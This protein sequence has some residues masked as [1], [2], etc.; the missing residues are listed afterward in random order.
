MSGP[1]RQTQETV[2]KPWGPQEEAY[3][4]L[5]A[6]AESAFGMTPKTPFAGDYFAPPTAAQ[7]SGAESVKAAAPGMSVGFPEIRNLGVAQARG[8][9]L[10]PESN[11]FLAATIEAAINPVLKKYTQ[12]IFP[13]IDD[14]SISGGAYGGARQSIEQE[15]AAED[16]GAE[17]SRVA[18]QI[19]YDNYLKERAIQQQTPQLLN[20]ANELSLAPGNTLL[21]VGGVEQGWDQDVLAGEYQR[22]LDSQSAPWA[23]LDKFAAALGAGGFG[24]QTQTLEK[25]ANP[26]TEILQGLVG[27][28]GLVRSF[29]NP[30]RNLVPSAVGMY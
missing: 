23:G 24:S 4:N 20:A 17:S 29:A 2:N 27:G 18:A 19:A 26:L 9:F 28:A 5:F 6:S 10:S 16:F 25:Q 3:K 14:A 30:F 22:W 11:P 13:A 7:L 15:K 12:N 8:D 21:G 1:S